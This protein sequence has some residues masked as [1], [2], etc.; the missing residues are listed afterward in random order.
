MGEREWGVGVGRAE[1][2]EGWERECRRRREV[3][4][5]GW[6]KSGKKVYYLCTKNQH[7]II[8]TCTNKKMQRT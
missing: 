3:R 2:R 5:E 1:R 4:R 8:I 6:E 7:N